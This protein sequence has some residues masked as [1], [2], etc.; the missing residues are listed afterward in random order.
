MVR[1]GCGPGKKVA[2]VGLGG[3]GHFAVLFGKAMGAEMT[4]ISHSPKKEADAKKVSYLFAER[5]D[6]GFSWAL[7]I[8]LIRPRRISRRSILWSLISLSVP[9]TLGKKTSRWMII[10][11]IYSFSVPR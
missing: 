11:R 5:A 6:F 7:S 9:P 1:H 8:S 10:F 3:L 4:A 2:V